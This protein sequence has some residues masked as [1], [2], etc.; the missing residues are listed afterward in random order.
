MEEN[1]KISNEKTTMEFGGI[2][3]SKQKGQ[4][5]REEKLGAMDVTVGLSK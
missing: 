5:T 4:D 3:Y 2:I 1:R